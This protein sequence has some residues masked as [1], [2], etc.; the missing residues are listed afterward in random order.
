MAIDLR[1]RGPLNDGPP[2]YRVFASFVV[3]SDGDAG[4]PD[5]VRRI[6]RLLA[7]RFDR[8]EIVVVDNRGED[9]AAGLTAMGEELS[10][11]LVHMVLARS[12][13]PERAMLAGLS[14]AMGDFVFE[15]SCVDVDWQPELLVEMFETCA[16]GVDI[17]D[18]SSHDPSWARRRFFRSLNRFSYLDIPDAPTSIRVVSRRALN[19]M[20]DMREKVRYRRA[21]YAATGFPHA[22]IR[23]EPTGASGPPDIGWLPRIGKG[24]DVMVSFSDFGLRLANLAALFFAA[25]ALGA[26]VYTLAVFALERDVVAGWTTLMLL[27]SFGLAG[28]FIVLSLL[29]EYLARILVEVRQ[30]PPYHLRSVTVYPSRV[31]R[32]QPDPAPLFD[33]AAMAAE[34]SLADRPRPPRGR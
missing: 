19:A 15:S 30:R 31:A 18:G 32:P 3:V 16:G 29:G 14:R 9:G 1:Y 26:L 13:D 12:H 21:L 11:T 6:D 34:F 24:F 28:V 20:L 23:Y 10:G 5:F 7:A 22:N 27:A 17:V 33:E 4:L 2:T 8:H 25:V